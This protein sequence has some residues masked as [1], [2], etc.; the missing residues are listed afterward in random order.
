M[1]FRIHFGFHLSANERVFKEGQLV[2]LMFK[3]VSMTKPKQ[4]ECG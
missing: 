2:K 1:S 3:F 4:N